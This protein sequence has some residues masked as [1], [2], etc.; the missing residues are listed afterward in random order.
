VTEDER[1]LRQRRGHHL[2][3]TLVHTRRLEV[4][5]DLKA[6]PLQLVGHLSEQMKMQ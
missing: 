5:V 6:H 3:V 1:F 2:L 4:R